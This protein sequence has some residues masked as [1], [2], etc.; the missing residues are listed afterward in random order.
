MLAKVMVL[1]YIDT[2]NMSNHCT[3]FLKAKL[4]NTGN[5]IQDLDV[6]F[7]NLN[8]EIA[9]WI[10]YCSVAL[11]VVIQSIWY[12]LLLFNF[13]QII[14]IYFQ[15]VE[16]SVLST[17]TLLGCISDKSARVGN[18]HAWEFFSE[19]YKLRVNILKNFHLF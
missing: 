16:T 9:L 8:F 12:V 13:N 18:M 5:S 3:S 17:K 11:F 6:H 14:L 1:H 4:S 15:T 2:K 7:L 19:F 10:C